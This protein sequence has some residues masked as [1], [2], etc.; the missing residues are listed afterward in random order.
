MVY[1]DVLPINVCVRIRDEN[2]QVELNKS[3]MD[4]NVVK[5][6]LQCVIEGGSLTICPGFYPDRVK[7]WN[8]LLERGIISVDKETNKVVYHL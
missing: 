1:G 4:K 5:K 2:I 6:I 7:A 8:S 3:F